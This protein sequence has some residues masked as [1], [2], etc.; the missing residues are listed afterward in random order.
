MRVEMPPPRPEAG[1]GFSLE[2][3]NGWGAEL[4]LFASEERSEGQCHT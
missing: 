4:P 2:I 1:A 3:A